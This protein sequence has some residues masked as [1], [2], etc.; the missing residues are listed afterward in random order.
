MPINPWPDEGNS[1]AGAPRSAPLLVTVMVKASPLTSMSTRARGGG[2]MLDHVGQR[3]LHDPV[4]GQTHLRRH[5][6][7]IAGDLHLHRDPG[8]PA[9]G[10]QAVQLVQ[11]GRMTIPA[12]VAAAEHAGDAPQL[13][14][15]VPP[16]VGH[17]TAA[18]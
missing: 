18:P 9:A 13:G 17:D 1:G 16:G 2:R 10:R 7:E 12:A 11:A 15:G 3:L 14:Q 4:G 5:R 6:A 8:R